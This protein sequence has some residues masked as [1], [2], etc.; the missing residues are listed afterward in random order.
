M[1]NKPLV[2][3]ITTVRN[4]EK[5]IG[6]S[7]QSILNQTYNEIEYIVVDDGSTDRTQEIVSDFLGDSRLNLITFETN[8]GR[9]ASLNTALSEATGKYIALHDADDISLPERIRKQVEFLETNPDHVLIGSNIVEIDAH[10]KEI[11][12]PRKPTENTDLQFSII[13]KCTLAN[14]S[15]MFRKKISDENKIRYEN[16]FIHAEDFGFISR[17]IRYGKV[18]N[19]EEILLKY[20]RHPNN[21]S[22]VN[23]NELDSSSTEI[24]RLNLWH[25]GLH[26]EPSQ[27]KRI[28][29]LISS[30]GISKDHVIEDVTVLLKAI[31]IYIK[32][33]GEGK[34]SEIELLLSRMPN[35]LGRKNILLKSSYKSINAKI[36]EMRKRLAESRH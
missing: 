9:I 3:V 8:I 22:R 20:R 23:F 24:A 14:P 10:G 29:D 33:Q 7:I 5:F 36:R 13:F 6:E 16:R 32:K 28:R 17:L 2:T 1:K 30:K 15:T 25:L 18:H 21:N 12:N 35:W 31:D 26:L 11:G 19:L 4:C 34:Y 27:V